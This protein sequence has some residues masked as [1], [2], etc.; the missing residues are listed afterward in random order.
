MK[1]Q[2]SILKL[3]STVNMHISY[4]FG[5]NTCFIFLITMCFMNSVIRHLQLV[6]SQSKDWGCLIIKDANHTSQRNINDIKH[7]V[8]FLAVKLQKFTNKI[9]EHHDEFILYEY[10]I[11]RH[12]IN[13]VFVCLYTL[14]STLSSAMFYTEFA[15]TL[16]QRDKQ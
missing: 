10:K 16:K 9:T 12:E 14:L 2:Y 15:V 5:L 8:L 11:N 7:M 13:L 4:C 6:K 3:N 1:V